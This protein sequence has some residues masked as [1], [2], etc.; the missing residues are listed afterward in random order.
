MIM[1][2]PVFNNNYFDNFL[3]KLR[4]LLRAL[5]FSAAVFTVACT[6]ASSLYNRTGS[7]SGSREQIMFQTMPKTIMAVGIQSFGKDAPVFSSAMIA[8]SGLINAAVQYVV[9]LTNKFFGPAW[10][11]RSTVVYNVLLIIALSLLYRMLKT[12]EHRKT[13]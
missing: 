6:F 8:I 10:G 13:A 11:Y 4:R 12:Q 1:F 9:G 3:L 7:L 2:F 5:A